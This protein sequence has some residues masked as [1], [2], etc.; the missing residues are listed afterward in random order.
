M[1]ETGFETYTPAQ[2]SLHVAWKTTREP[3]A[4]QQCPNQCK[5][6]QPLTSADHHK[7]PQSRRSSRTFQNWV[8]LVGLSGYARVNLRFRSP[9]FS[10]FPFGQP[11]CSHHGQLACV[12]ANQRDEPPSALPSG[13]VPRHHSSMISGDR[14]SPRSWTG[15]SSGTACLEGLVSRSR[16]IISQ[17]KA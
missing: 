9:P 3:D 12:T 4:H 15:E 2:T 1:G 14:P 5:R 11:T 16:A 8:G 13:A 10:S 17:R 6:S 7:G